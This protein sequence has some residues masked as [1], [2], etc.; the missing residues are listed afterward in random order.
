MAPRVS[1][2]LTASRPR[3]RAGR[4]DSIEA[5][6]YLD[7]LRRR[8]WLIAL[9]ALAAV[10]GAFVV[11]SWAPDR[12]KAT[13]SIV[14]QVTTGPYESVNV[15]A[16]TRELSTIEQLLLTSD[17][18]DR[19]AK[20]V[21]GESPGSV[22]AALEASVDPDANLIF[23]TATAGDPK[24]AADIANAVATTFIETQRDVVRRQYVQARAGLVQ[25]LKRVQGQ[26]GQAQQEQAIRQRLS[27]LGVSLAGAGM[28]LQIAEPATP[29]D[30]R[31]SPK[32]LRNAVIDALPISLGV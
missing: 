21:R 5:R 15:D 29:P 2:A 24:K 16:L 3:R 30:Q 12:Y 28:D 13:A 25:E 27:E 1:P 19:A 20:R 26:P 32:P 31:S 8:S 22:R 10:A 17:V 18:L 9:L 6:R 23:V 7:A 14:K 11:S 4:D